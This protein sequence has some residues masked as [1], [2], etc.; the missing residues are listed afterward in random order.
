MR[1]A[2]S[3]QKVPRSDLH[4]NNCENVI[5]KTK[6]NKSYLFCVTK[7]YYQNKKISQAMSKLPII[8]HFKH[9]ESRLF[10]YHVQIL[11][12]LYLHDEHVSLDG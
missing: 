6:E 10:M 1:P 9:I 4:L 7:I 5:Q 8:R 12:Q 3:L 2:R 11:T